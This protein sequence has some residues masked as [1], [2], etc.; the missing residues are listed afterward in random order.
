MVAYVIRDATGNL[1]YNDTQMNSYTRY[2]TIEAATKEL[3]DLP[4]TYYI[5]L[6][7]SKKKVE[8]TNE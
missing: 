2:G 8:L 4:A 5:S 1:Y 6:I 7:N 3:K